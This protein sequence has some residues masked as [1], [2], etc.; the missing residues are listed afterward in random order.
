M[1]NFIKKKSNV[2]AYRSMIDFND[3]YINLLPCGIFT[4]LSK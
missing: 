2:I 3:N 4:I 1:S